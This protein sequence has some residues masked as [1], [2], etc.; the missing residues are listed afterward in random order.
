MAEDAVI[1]QAGRT[2]ERPSGFSDSPPLT[3]FI[4]SGNSLR[5]S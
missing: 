4:S 1:I 2:I 5:A 3:T